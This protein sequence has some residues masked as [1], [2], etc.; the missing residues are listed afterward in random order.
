MFHFE[1]HWTLNFTWTMS[2]EIIIV[3]L[4][5]HLSVRPS[6]SFLK[7]RS[8]V[9]SVILHDDNRPWYL[10]TDEA[11]FLGKKGKKKK[12][13]EPSEPKSS[14]KLVFFC[15]FLEFGS[16]FFFEIAHSNS[17]WQCLTASRGKT[18]EK[19]FF[20]GPPNLRQI[21]QNQAQN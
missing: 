7:I 8:L 11:R 5:V 15:H 1:F 13:N 9:F 16:Y 21:G 3:C 10:V 6:L 17:L 4:S 12:K 14:P 19:N 18:D 2:Y 20:G